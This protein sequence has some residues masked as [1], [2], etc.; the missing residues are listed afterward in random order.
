MA[1]NA[2]I[3]DKPDYHAFAPSDPR[4]VAIF[5]RIVSHSPAYLE[6]DYGFSSL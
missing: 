6:A 1:H 5:D 2:E 4:R 3:R